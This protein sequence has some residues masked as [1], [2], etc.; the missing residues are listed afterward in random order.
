M[1]ELRLSISEVANLFGFTNSVVSVYEFKNIYKLR[2]FLTNYFFNLIRII[3]VCK[4]IKSLY[5]FNT[6]LDKLNNWI[7]K[8][9]VAKECSSNKHGISICL[10]YNDVIGI[11]I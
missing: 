8:A 4:D 6:F 3:Y 9:N 1:L 7:N 5:L 2:I 11:S 10:L